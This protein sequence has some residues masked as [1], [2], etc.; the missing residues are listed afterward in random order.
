LEG[1]TLI[2]TG[3][4]ISFQNNTEFTHMCTVKLNAETAAS[5]QFAIQHHYW[6]Q[7]YIDELPV[8]AMVGEE[9]GD[10]REEAL[11]N[12]RHAAPVDLKP[13]QNRHLVYTHMKLS[14]G[15]TGNRITEVCLLENSKSGPISP[16]PR[17]FS[18]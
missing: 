17:F 9:Q 4:K 11:D 14:I 1:N 12:P 10:L 18:K 3:I 2:N 15:Y 13:G 6:Y 16:D 8:W 5:F 7:M